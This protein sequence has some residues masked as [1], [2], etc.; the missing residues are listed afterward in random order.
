MAA[1]EQGYFEVSL[2]KSG[3]GAK[4]THRAT[5]AGLGLRR[6]GQTVVRK[7]TPCVRGM[8]YKVVHLVQ[9]A[10][11]GPGAPSARERLAALTQKG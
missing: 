8:L 10:P 2:K 11:C 1:T 3:A 4:A 7:D 5:L 9:I 6:M